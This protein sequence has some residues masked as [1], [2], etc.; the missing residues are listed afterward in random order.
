MRGTRAVTLAAGFC[1]ASIVNAAPQAAPRVG[2][3]VQ[4]ATAYV[5]RYT[6]ELKFVL[7]EEEYTPRTLGRNDSIERERRIRGE[8][9][10]AFL[11]AD[12]G[13]IA[14]RDVHEVDG[15]AVADREDLHALL[16]QGE[17]SSVARRVADRNASFNIGRILRNFNEPTLPLLLLTRERVGRTRFR[18]VSHTARTATLAFQERDRPALI[19]SRSGEHAFSRGTL[20]VDAQTGRVEATT[21]ELSIDG[22]RVRLETTYTADERLGL[23]VPTTFTERYEGRG[24]T[25]ACRA[26]YSN[27]RRFEVLGRV[28]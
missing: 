10:L 17:V 24:E 6:A 8:F 15:A 1:A 28:K 9:F 16:R 2:E 27:Y 4:L 25:I 19:R 7:A 13:W 20:T 12:R 26:V 21:L 14:V 3:V 22:I 18:A 5:Q 11:A 23:W